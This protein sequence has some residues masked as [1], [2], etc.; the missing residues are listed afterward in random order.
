MV[1]VR[2]SGF[3]RDDDARQH[4]TSVRIL[5]SMPGFLLHTVLEGKVH[6]FFRFPH[7]LRNHGHR[8]FEVRKAAAMV[9]QNA[10][11]HLRRLR[12]VGEPARYWLL[13]VDLAIFD[14]EMKTCCHKRLRAAGNSKYM[15]GSHWDFLELVGEPRGKQANLLAWHANG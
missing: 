7:L 5:H 11:R 10:N 2:P 3:A 12:H 14:Q 9:K 13:E 1:G 4:V 15:V 6:N 8:S